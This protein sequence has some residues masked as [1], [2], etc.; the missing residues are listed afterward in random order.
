[1]GRRGRPIPSP[2][3]DRP[4]FVGNLLRCFLWQTCPQAF[5]L[6]L[7]HRVRFVRII[8]GEGL[9]GSHATPGGDH[10]NCVSLLREFPLFL[11]FNNPGGTDKHHRFFYARAIFPLS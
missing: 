4:T 1:M 11:L 5:A 10:R 2:H 9:I 3:L 7:A 8:V 6:P